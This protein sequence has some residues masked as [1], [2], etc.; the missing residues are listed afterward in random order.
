MA[1]HYCFFLH[2]YSEGAKDLEEKDTTSQDCGINCKGG[3]DGLGSRL[4]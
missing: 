3:S 4:G 2:G 1:K